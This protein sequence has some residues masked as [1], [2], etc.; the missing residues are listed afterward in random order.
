MRLQSLI[1]QAAGLLLACNGVEAATSWGF[2]DA[3]LTVQGKGSGVGSGLKE[4]SVFSP[5]APFPHVHISRLNPQKALKTEVAFGPS[6]SLKIVLTTQEGKTAKR[7]NQA[8]LLLQ[9]STSNLDVSYPF[10]VKESGK[11][12]VELVRTL[13]VVASAQVDRPTQTHKDLPSQ[14]LRSKSPLSASLVIAS[15]GTTDGYN[16]EI[17]PLKIQL[18]SNAPVPAAEK[19]LRYGKQP[20]IQ[21]VFRGDPKSPNFLLVAIF[22]A[23]TL[24]TLPVLFGLVRTHSGTHHA[25]PVA[26]GFQWLSVGVNVSHISKAFSDAPVSHGLFFGS[27]LAIEGAFFLYYTAWNLFQTLPVLA[28]FGTVAYVSGSRALSEVQERRLAGLR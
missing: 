23:A 10:S 4:K 6:D 20:E 5:P 28:I 21:H 2:A 1:L 9:D 18:D 12:K 24:A 13:D 22:S 26:N 11:G 3:T 16:S 27:I 25:S 15:F 14:F 19:P 8:F 7:P 17:F